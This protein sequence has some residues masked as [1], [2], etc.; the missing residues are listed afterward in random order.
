M[1]L[2]FS[3]RVVCFEVE[4]AATA[5]PYSSVSPSAVVLVQERSI[6]SRPV[7]QEAVRR[8]VYIK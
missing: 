6:P 4:S 3:V 7:L 5:S 8:G 2:N 1:N